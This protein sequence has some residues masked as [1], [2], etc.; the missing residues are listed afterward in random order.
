M[1]FSGFSNETI[2]FFNEL[3][4]NNNSAWFAENKERHDKFITTPSREF[5]KSMG[6][7]LLVLDSSIQAVPKVN[8]S[9]FRINRDTRFSSDKTP[10][11]T[12]LGLWFWS[13]IRPR[14]ECSGLYFNLEGE[15]LYLASGIYIFTKPLL[16]IYRDA[17]ANPKLC[18]ELIEITEELTQKG[19]VVGGTHYKKVPSGYAAGGAQ[20]ELLKMNGLYCGFETPVPAEF[21]SSELLDYCFIHYQALLPL[22][23]WL[24][25]VLN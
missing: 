9:I 16:S 2:S 6:E 10:Y 4:Q 19:Y 5:I 22:H 3:R 23:L 14:M 25:K 20:A 12:N 13:G 1:S 15:N 11:K 17:V 24:R 21:Y 18:N 7:M 8:G